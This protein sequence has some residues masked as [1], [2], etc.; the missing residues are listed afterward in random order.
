MSTHVCRS[1]MY[2]AA[3]QALFS[4]PALFFRI[5]KQASKP[6]RYVCTSAAQCWPHYCC[7][8]FPLLLT[9]FITTAVVLT[10]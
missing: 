7:F 4:F 5:S 6:D 8:V 3:S 1:S 9:V 10:A 2:I